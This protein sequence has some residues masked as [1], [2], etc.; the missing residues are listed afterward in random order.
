MDALGQDEIF[1]AKVIKIEPREKIIEG[2][3]TY[4]V[5]FL[6]TQKIPKVIK[7]GMSANIEIIINKKEGVVIIPY[8]ALII[9]DSKTFV[10]VLKDKKILEKEVK[11]G[12]KST[13]GEV[14]IIKG[15][16]GGEKIIIE[17][18]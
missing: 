14:E 7:P 1:K 13:S 11:T 12:I 15:L 8:R 18:E 17:S 3:P 6:F 10:K 5:E 4:K 16:K 9:K 2:I